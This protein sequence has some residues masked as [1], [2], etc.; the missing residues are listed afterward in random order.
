MATEI[1]LP[2]LGQGM[3]SGTVVRWLKQEGERV[4]K[5]EPLYELDTEKVTQEVEADASGV[6][7]KIAVQ[8]GEV[9]VGQTIAVIGEEGEEVSAEE[10]PEPEAEAE[11]EEAPE[12]EGSR[13]PARDE[14]RERARAVAEPEAEPGPEPA[15]EPATAD[16]RVKASPLARRIAR[17]RG[18]ELA[19]VRG[20]GPEGRIVA[21]D[22]ERAVA[23]PPRPEA[24]AAAPGEAEVV[25]LTSIRKTIARRLT[26]AW[27]APVFQISMS[28]DMTRAQ[29]LRERLVEMTREGETKPTVSDV[30]TKACAVALMR[31]P[32]LNAHYAGEEV[33]RFPTADVGMAVATDRGL[34]VPVIRSAERLNLAEIAAARADLVTRARD[35]KLQQGDLEGGTFTTSNLGMYGVEEFIAVL[36][37]PQVAILAVGAI[38]DKPVVVDG[39]LEIKPMMSLTLTCDHRAVDGA[40]AAEFLGTVR[41]LLEEPALAL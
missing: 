31:H 37:P 26:Q 21:E 28:A 4:E 30:I 9:P 41:A 23:A 2:R 7:L 20:T 15:P 1:K 39:D 3:E 27:E 19:Q 32:E 12:E 5:G 40:D 10:E 18:I 35:A 8:E 17:E 11:V 29:E 6:L 14:E 16:G 33:R 24:P 36:N 22:V 34:V 13:A 25:P 38:E